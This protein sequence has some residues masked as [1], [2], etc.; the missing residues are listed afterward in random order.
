M[1]V[2]KI[3]GIAMR[4]I[5]LIHG[6]LWI[7]A[8][9]ATHTVTAQPRVADDPCVSLYSGDG[10]AAPA[11]TPVRVADDGVVV[12]VSR[13]VGFGVYAG[14]DRHVVVLHQKTNGKRAY[15]RYGEV[16]TTLQVGTKLKRGEELGRVGAR[17]EFFFEVRPITVAVDQ[18]TPNWAA[19]LPSDPSKFNLQT[20]EAGDVAE[21]KPATWARYQ[22]GDIDE[23]TQRSL[24]LFAKGQGGTKIFP[25]ATPYRLRVEMV[26]DPFVCDTQTLRQALATVGLNP[27]KPVNYC[28]DLRSSSGRITRAYV[29]DLVAFHMAREI[30][31]GEK[32]EVFAIHLYTNSP[33]GQ[34]TLGGSQGGVLGLVVNEFNVIQ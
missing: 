21:T 7:V 30:A 5:G 32:M 19:V 14:C 2:Q 12:S 24:A 15:T 4:T 9:I 11:G 18:T 10:Y 29:Q 3:Q 34:G 25:D 31:V 23:V 1:T 22:K 26:A 17:G 8:S 16:T 33:T 6:L 28:V 20:Y 27:P 13:V